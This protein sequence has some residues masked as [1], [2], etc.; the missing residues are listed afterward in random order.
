MTSQV[1]S[2]AG[3]SDE[4]SEAV[5]GEQRAPHIVRAGG[6]EKEIRRLDRV[7]IRFAGDSGDGMQLTGDRF[8]S[9]TASFGN[10]LSTLPNFP[11][12]IRA[13]AG[14]LPGVS[15]FQLHFADHD[16][17]T[18]GD[19]PNVLVAMNPAALKANI[20]DVP[21]GADIIV[22]TDEFTKRPMAKVGYAES[23]LE[24]G[25]LEAYNVHPV[26]LTTLTIEA[27]KEFGLSRKEAERSKNMFALGLLSWMYNRP[28]EGT[29]TFLRSKFARKPN[30]AEA[31]VAAF[32]AGWNFGE[33]TEDF[34]V[35]Y[36]VAPASQAFPT[37]TYRNISGNL[38]LSYGLI[39]AGRQADLPVYLGSYP[40]TP[41]SDILHELSK[42][43]NFGVRTFQA[44]DEIAGIG[45]ALG[46]AFGGSLGVTTTSGPGVALKSETIGLAVSLELPLLIIDIQRGGPSTGLPTKTEQADLL[47]AMYGRNGEAPVPI[48]APMT[49]ADCFD[50]ALDAA[51]IALTYRT[52][53]FLLSD[54]YLANGSEPWRIPEA[55]SLPDL[56]TRFA[57]GPNHELADGTEV[58]WPYK[59]DPETL[60]RPWAVPGTPGL[61]HRIGG[62]E[63]QDGTGNI[64]YDPANHDFMVRTRQAKID[65]IRVP[66]LEVDD[67]AGATTLV[68]GWGSTYGPITAAVRR[69]RAAGDTIAQAHLRHLNPFPANLGEVLRRYDKVVVPEMNLGQLALLLRARY[70]VDARSFNQV[71]GMPFKA[72]QLATVLKEAIDA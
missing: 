47:Q 4:A 40:I 49:P 42:H 56:R 68:L 44:E 8:T 6:T 24:D 17:L 71:N 69:L 58:F 64:S 70:L 48:V 59:R 21:R 7:I 38:A 36:E 2:P 9:E 51:R 18:P 63:K 67:P 3:K 62:I 33:T 60:A 52:P 31:N 57:T 25:S 45:A 27:L 16:I 46:A 35:S 20:A 41:A 43:K 39:A 29:E 22:N 30:I 34:A 32:R 19:A 12:E 14:T 5:V 1:S 72:E 15:S 37:G 53:V 65:G 66:D 10:D 50:A 61:E 11:A 13:P 54:G 28:T 26:P 55:D 23:P